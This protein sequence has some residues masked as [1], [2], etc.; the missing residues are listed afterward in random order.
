M[1]QNLCILRSCRRPCWTW[2]LLI[3]IWLKLICFSG[4][5][6]LKSMLFKGQLDIQVCVFL[7][8]YL[9]ET[10][11]PWVHVNTSNSNS[12]QQDSFMFITD[13]NL[14]LIFLSYLFIYLFD[15]LSSMEPTSH[16]QHRPSH[17]NAFLISQTPPCTVLSPS[18]CSTPC[19]AAH[20]SLPPLSPAW[21]PSQVPSEKK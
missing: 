19:R 21:A 4:L 5:T 16:H 12:I 17:S 14:P 18:G 10:M 11:R 2:V 9:L 1:Y 20:L 13:R 8:L 15:Q 7:Y 6:Q 3:C